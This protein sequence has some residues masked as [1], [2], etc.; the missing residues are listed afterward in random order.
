MRID[1]RHETRPPRLPARPNG[2]RPLFIALIPPSVRC[3]GVRAC[4]GRPLGL[5]HKLLCA[6]R[7]EAIGIALLCPSICVM[8]SGLRLSRLVLE[9]VYLSVF[10]LPVKVELFEV[11]LE[12]SFLS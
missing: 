8:S 3:V 5:A 7:N 6:L 11:H 2:R 10:I 12:V 4:A 1:R 9:K